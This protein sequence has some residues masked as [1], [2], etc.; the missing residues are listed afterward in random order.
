MFVRKI[1]FVLAAILVSSSALP[2]PAQKLV[3]IDVTQSKTRPG[4]TSAYGET[5]WDFN[6]VVGAD[7]D[8]AL[9]ARGF[10]T[11]VVIADANSRAELSIVDRM[12]QFAG[13]SL[14]VSVAGDS[15]PGHYY[16]YW[17]AS[18]RRTAYV[19]RFSGYSVSVS[20]VAQSEDSLLCGVAIASALRLSGYRSSDHRPELVVVGD[21]AA[22]IADADGP[23]FFDES[24]SPLKLASVPIVLL[25]AGVLQNPDDETL[26]R[27]VPYRKA[28]LDKVAAG[29]VGCLGN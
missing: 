10:A 19:D 18:G 21:H 1:C 16:K 7:L 14:V 2:S 8:A 27:Q 12:K 11:R 25:E 23:V 20:K 15:M 22:A 4:T 26:L 17:N 9:R 3:V 29:I 6:R 5:E 24:Y 28:M 13:A